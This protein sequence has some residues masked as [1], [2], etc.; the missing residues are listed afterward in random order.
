MA[1][2]CKARAAFGDAGTIFVLME[3]R[4]E[5][6]VNEDGFKTRERGAE[7]ACAVVF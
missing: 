6:V 5:L 3:M 4:G 7:D 1:A 2:Y